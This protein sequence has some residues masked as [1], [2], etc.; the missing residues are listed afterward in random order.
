MP[1]CTIN[2][3]IDALLGNG[4]SLFE[5]LNTFD[6]WKDTDEFFFT[7]EQ[8]D[9][10]DAE[11]LDNYP[12][13]YK[14]P[15]NGEHFYVEGE[16]VPQGTFVFREKEYGFVTGVKREIVFDSWMNFQIRVVQTEENVVFETLI[17]LE[18][19]SSVKKRFEFDK[20]S[21]AF[22]YART[23][24]TEQNHLLELYGKYQD[25]KTGLYFQVHPVFIVN[26]FFFTVVYKEDIN[27]EKFI[28]HK[29]W[30]ENPFK[31]IDKIINQHS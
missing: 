18:D 20:I 21:S 28:Q 22:I 11:V 3:L 15:Y 5:A 17:P 29:E 25:K 31:L 4:M 14:V 24:Q 2:P 23:P 12:L 19:D 30:D 10:S 1:K 26:D 13:I 8:V 9:T 16:H 6:G 27:D 7:E